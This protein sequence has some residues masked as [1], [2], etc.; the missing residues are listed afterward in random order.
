VDDKTNRLDRTKEVW[1]RKRR[2]CVAVDCIALNYLGKHKRKMAIRVINY[3][4][5]DQ[6]QELPQ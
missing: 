4:E 2:I 5:S 3:Q 1:R 6:Q